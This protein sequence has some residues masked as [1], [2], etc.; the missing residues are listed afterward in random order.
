M[1]KLFFRSNCEEQ[2]VLNLSELFLF[3]KDSDDVLSFRFNNPNS[4]ELTEI[5]LEYETEAKRDKDYSRLVEL[6]GAKSE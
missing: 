6:L 5:N 2:D 1:D 4:D 3:C